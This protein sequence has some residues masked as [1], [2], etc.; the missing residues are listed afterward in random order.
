M[1][2][3]RFS[4]QKENY[5]VLLMGGAGYLGSVLA[6]KL[7]AS[8]RH[9]RVLDSFM[10]GEQ[11]LD[12]VRTDPKCEL[13]RGDVR[14]VGIVVRCMQGC[15]EVIHLAGIVGDSACEENQ[16]LAVEVNRAATRMLTDVALE[17][18]VRRFVFASSCSVYGA[19]DLF[20]NEASPV[21]PLS[22]YAE[23]KVESERILLE[24]KNATFAPTILR[25]GTLFGLS[26]R[27]RFDLVVN[28]LVAR[29]VF[30]RK[31]AILN[32]AQWRPLIHVSDAARA[33]VTSLEAAA[34]TV[35]GEV[36]N[37]GAAW[38][39]LQ[40]EQLGRAVAR[41]ISGTEIEMLQNEDR[42]N[43]RVT[44]DKIH[45]RLGFSCS[46]TM[47]YGMQEIYD[48]IR[49][50]QITDFTTAQFNN[51]F[52]LRALVHAGAKQSSP[53]REMAASVTMTTAEN[54]TLKDDSVRSHA[55]GV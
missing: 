55:A 10:F 2:G 17:C 37:V 53:L 3:T 30:M 36:F 48:A 45:E 13:V 42:R 4:D 31:I 54:G 38:L 14:D 43:Y 35:T 50:G 26:P 15:D 39:N 9:V 52:A 5:R 8:G 21:N 51:Q 1:K 46:K 6:A 33:F 34:D 40:I 27:M 18:G 19:S 25:L 47:E 28:L 16:Q 20:L 7:L 41:V 12:Q 49:A 22:L 11:S 24:A 44:F 29:A 32:G 23:M